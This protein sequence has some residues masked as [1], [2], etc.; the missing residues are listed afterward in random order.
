VGGRVGPEPGLH[1]FPQGGIAGARL[2]QESGPFCE[3][4]F[5]QGGGEHGIFRHGGN[6][7]SH[8]PG[9]ASGGRAQRVVSL[10]LSRKEERL[11]PLFFLSFEEAGTSVAIGGYGFPSSC[12]MVFP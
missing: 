10:F 4:G 9:R 7:L 3:V 11:T 5:F 1:T 2:V 6:S 8:D 12:I